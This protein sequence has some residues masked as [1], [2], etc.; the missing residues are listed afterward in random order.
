MIQKHERDWVGD[1]MEW[2]YLPE[3]CI[4]TNGALHLSTRTLAGL[5]VC[6][7]RMRANLDLTNGLMLS[8]AIM[9]ALAQKIGRQT[10]HIV[11]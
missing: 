11:V 2:A 1:H 8:E 10:A 7:E 3:L 4:M 5:L 9:L 6:P